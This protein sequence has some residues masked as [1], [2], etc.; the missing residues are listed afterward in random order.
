[1]RLPPTGSP[2][3]NEWGDGCADEQLLACTRDA[4]CESIA[5]ATVALRCAHGVCV[6]DT[7]AVDPRAASPSAIY[8]ASSCYSHRDCNPDPANATLM[9]SG[10]GR[11]VSK[12]AGLP[13]MQRETDA[14]CPSLTVSQC[15]AKLTPAVQV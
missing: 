11:R 7:G 9:C 1:M 15:N 6:V 12:S 14:R 8:A 5:P 4:D 2:N 10:D 13:V 3:I